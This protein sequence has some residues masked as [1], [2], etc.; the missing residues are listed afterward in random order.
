MSN[1]SLQLELLAN[2]YIQSGSSVIFDNIVYNSGNITY[3]TASG[4][5]TFTEA[6]RYIL[7][8]WVATQTA[9][10]PNF[11]VFALTSSQGDLIE[12]NSPVK[13]G[14][15]VGF[16]II[17]V[18]SA[19]VTLTLNYISEGTAVLSSLVPVKATLV[20][21]QDDIVS[22][23]SVTGPTGA[24]GV[25]GETG[26][27]G[28]TGVTGVTGATG[29]T[30]DTGATGITGPTGATGET[31]V[32]GS[33]GVTG[34]TGE[35]GVT[36]STG[37]TGATGETGATGPQQLPFAILHS[38]QITDVASTDPLPIE[39]LQYQSENFVILNNNTFAL[40]L[41]GVYQVIINLNASWVET[42]P[43]D[44]LAFAV[45][46]VNDNTTIIGLNGYQASYVAGSDTVSTHITGIGRLH[47]DGTDVFHVV[48]IN[49]QSIRLISVNSN[50]TT[51]STYNTSTTMDISILWVAPYTPFPV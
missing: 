21:V 12:G 33:T 8:W 50:F 44:P 6:G 4:V 13:T 3:D 22:P 10:S 31:G 30:G 38:G 19:P 47:S 34:A 20:I 49:T 16:G 32:T 35:T 5:V 15:V 17:N 23:T 26:A 2:A 11:V 42:P 51:S 7:N 1:S 37:V 14:E 43:G 24:S 39:L 45:Q 46:N 48:N 27:T 18:V 36:G 25:T 29:A 40:T 41:P 28:D 9:T